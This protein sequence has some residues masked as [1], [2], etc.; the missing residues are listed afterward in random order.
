[1]ACSSVMSFSRY[2]LRVYPYHANE[3]KHERCNKGEPFS[4]E[5]TL[6]ALSKVVGRDCD[7]GQ[8]TGPTFA[9]FEFSY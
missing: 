6:C 9:L 5:V 1:M 3:K 4:L 2:L 8:E 7:Q